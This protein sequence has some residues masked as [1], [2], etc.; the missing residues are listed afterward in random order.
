MVVLPRHRRRFRNPYGGGDGSEGYY[1][2]PSHQRGQPYQQHQHAPSSTTRSMILLIAGMGIGYLVLPVL[3]V[4][5]ASPHSQTIG[6]NDVIQNIERQ[7]SAAAAYPQTNNNGMTDQS[8]QQLSPLNLVQIV[9]VMWLLP[10]Y[11]GIPPSMLI[12]I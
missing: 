9:V 1:G 8:S 6:L 11:G 2:A 4:N 3:M 12:I 10:C 7:K 5:N